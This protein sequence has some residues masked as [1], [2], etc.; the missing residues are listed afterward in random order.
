MNRYLRDQRRHVGA[1][2]VSAR[3]EQ[4][5]TQ[6]AAHAQR[7]GELEEILAARDRGLRELWAGLTRMEERLGRS[8]RRVAS[9]ERELARGRHPRRVPAATAARRLG[10]SSS[11]V[12]RLIEAGD[13][14]GAALQLPDRE[15][16]AWVV[17]ATDLERLERESGAVGALGAATE[18]AAGHRG[19]TKKGS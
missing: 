13:L 5:E 3:I 8:D 15:R 17:D 11:S 18:S 19:S 9:L 16:R 7:I 2:L 1:Q 4:L 10:V 14:R 6:L 12:R